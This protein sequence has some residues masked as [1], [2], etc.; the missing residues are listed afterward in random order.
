MTLIK[1]FFDH[2]QCPCINGI[3]YPDE[4]VQEIHILSDGDFF[5]NCKIYAE[6]KISIQS[7]E[8]DKMIE[9]WNDCAILFK[10]TYPS[11]NIRIL[12]GESDYG[13]NGFISLIDAMSNDLIWMAF[14]ENSNPF[15]NASINNNCLYAE[16]TNGYQW[17]FSLKEPIKIAIKK[18]QH[19]T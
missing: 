10:E 11:L 7:L 17:I 13:D 5:E 3:F 2:Q 1:K 16:S 9:D 15:N 12:A 8:E 18:S 14:F 6:K 19:P 4:T